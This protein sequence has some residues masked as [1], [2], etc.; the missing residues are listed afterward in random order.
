MCIDVDSEGLPSTYTDNNNQDVPEFSLQR[1]G[2]N[3]T[4]TK[5]DS[6]LQRFYNKLE[7][8]RSDI[9][10]LC[11]Q[12]WKWNYVYATQSN[13]LQAKANKIVFI[14][15]STQHNTTVTLQSVLSHVYAVGL[16]RPT[17]SVFS[18]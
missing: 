4:E 5:A 12:A 13:L 15:P 10:L 1:I 14:V 2:Q 9:F 8:T 17:S 6:V 7:F 3:P 18:M 16:H 11:L